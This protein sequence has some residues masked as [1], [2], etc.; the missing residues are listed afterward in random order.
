MHDT[1]ERLKIGYSQKMET[2]PEPLHRTLQR[3]GFVPPM[4][5]YAEYIWCVEQ[6]IEIT[7]ERKHYADNI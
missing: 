5:T 7:M 2:M 1:V 3:L 6:D 4:M